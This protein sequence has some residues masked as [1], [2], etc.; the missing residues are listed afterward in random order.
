MAEPVQN[1]G[2]LTDKLEADRQKMA[3][4]VTELQESYNLSRWF[5]VSVRK[6]PW[7]CILSA[8]IFGFLLSRVPARKK[9]VYVWLP[10]RD[11]PTRDIGG[12]SIQGKQV[13]NL[14]PEERRYRHK[15]K[16]RS[17]LVF[18]LWSLIKPILTAYVA[19][20]I[21]SRL[22]RLRSDLSTA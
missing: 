2:D 19:R 12:A 13:K 20:Q 8:A 7:G 15:E 18:K 17:S 4:Q 21:Y 3:A 11:T 5:R 6:Y 22:S 1:K 10:V 14:P 16:H 9:E